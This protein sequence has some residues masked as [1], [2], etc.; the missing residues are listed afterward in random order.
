MIYYNSNT[1]KDW[2]LGDDNIIK[3]YKDNA[4]CYQKVTS[5][6]PPTPPAHDYSQD[7]LTFRALEDGTFSFSSFSNSGL[8]YSIDSGSTWV[9]FVVEAEE[10]TVQSGNTIMWKGNIV[11]SFIDGIGMFYS[12]GR[13]DVEGNIMS[14]LYGDNFIGQ[15]SLSGKDWAFA[16]LFKWCENLINAENLVLPATTLAYACYQDMFNGCTSLTTAPELPATTLAGGCYHMMFYYCP[17]L[18]TAPELPATTL[19]GGCYVSMF[20]ECHSLTTAPTLSATTLAESCYQLMFYNCTSL[21][22]VTCLATDISAEGCT[23]F[24]LDGVASDGTF[25]KACEMCSWTSG[26]SGIPSTWSIV[27]EGDGECE[28]SHDYS[29]DYLTFRAKEDGTFSISRAGASYSLDSGETW[30]SIAANVNTPTVQSGNTIMWKGTMLPTTTYGIGTFS[31]TGNFE[32][33]GNAMSLLYGDNFSGETNLSTKRYA[34]LGLFKGCSNLQSAENII[35]PATTLSINC[36]KHMFSG[37]T[38]LTTAPELP[39]TTLANYCYEGMLQ[40]CTSLTTAPQLPATTLAQYCYQWM[41]V[42]CTSLTTAPQLPATT[43]ANYCYYYMFSGCTSLTTAQQLPAT[44]LAPYCY[45]NMF[46]GCTS[47]TT[48]PQL[49]ATTLA[50]L[51]YQQMFAGCTSLTT[52]PELPATTLAN[53]CYGGMF[54]GCT[55]LSAITCLATDISATN[56]T[57]NWLYN[58]SSSGTFTKAASMND[59][60]SGTS[61]VPL[62]WTVQNYT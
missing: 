39:A 17:S 30:T 61:G 62:T 59:W 37:C 27:N 6:A 51:C 32:A 52:A 1:I 2:N 28:C 56:C 49:P 57:N 26:E 4:V 23:D 36:Y 21:S 60:T 47:L 42:G 34:F 41:F 16:S 40:R 5:D 19:A 58:V 53:N 13:F 48:A 20:E 12:S 33:Q 14:L 9:E 29:Q 24:W 44:T 11:P 3:V 46:M 22:A 45:A 18:T 50:V 8:S 25:T 7:Y 55:S 10:P 54:Y 43:L 15:T 31:S 38:S 35:L